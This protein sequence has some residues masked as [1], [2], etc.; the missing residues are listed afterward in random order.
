MSEQG[1]MT[2]DAPT[3]CP[4]VITNQDWQDK[5][6]CWELTI[7]QKPEPKIIFKGSRQPTLDEMVKVLSQSMMPTVFVDVFLVLCA[8]AEREICY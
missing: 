5:G 3:Y 6:A 8:F 7:Q 1:I 2:I 4:L